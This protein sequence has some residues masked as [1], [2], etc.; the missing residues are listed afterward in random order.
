MARSSRVAR[1]F[2]GYTNAAAGRV[3]PM[4]AL[5]GS[6]SGVCYFD[7]PASANEE[8]GD[9]RRQR[10]PDD[11]VICACFELNCASCQ[12]VQRGAIREW[13]DVGNRRFA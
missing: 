13:N 4:R 6:A 12:R 1:V 7:A 9:V 5:S 11:P 3:R 8:S 10:R 2:I